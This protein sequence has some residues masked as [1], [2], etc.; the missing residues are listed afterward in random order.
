MQVST[1]LPVKS[2]GQRGAWG[3]SFR[4]NLF[5]VFKA[6]SLQTNEFLVFRFDGRRLELMEQGMAY[7]MASA[8]PG[9]EA[10]RNGY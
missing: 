3:V 5:T 10:S 2:A 6:D 4:V 8:P 1:L 7:T 9:S